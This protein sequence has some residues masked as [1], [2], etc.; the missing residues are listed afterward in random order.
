MRQQL[1]DQIEWLS[2]ED[3]YGLVLRKLDNTEQ[4]V[5]KYSPVIYQGNGEHY[6]L[7][8]NSNKKAETYFYIRS[9][10]NVLYTPNAQTQSV[11][12]QAEVSITFNINVDL[13]REHIKAEYSLQEFIRQARQVNLDEFPTLKNPAGQN[14]RRVMKLQTVFFNRYEDIYQDFNFWLLDPNF[15]FHPQ[16]AFR[17]LYRMEFGMNC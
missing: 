13:I 1:Y 5:Q 10:Y 14:A 7:S 4:G 6:D 15:T 17:L 8:V 3:A 9:N 2:E 12:Y 16:N 11:F